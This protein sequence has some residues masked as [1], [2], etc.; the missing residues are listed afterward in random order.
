[1]LIERIFGGA[2]RLRNAEWVAVITCAV[3]QQAREGSLVAVAL[4]C[5]AFMAGRDRV[6]VVACDTLCEEC[7]GSPRSDLRSSPRIYGDV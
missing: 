2:H 1:M 6:C 7:A 4:A 5:G 3:D